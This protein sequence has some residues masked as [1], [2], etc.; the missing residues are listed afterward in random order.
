MAEIMWEGG[1]QSSFTICTELDYKL[2][3]YLILV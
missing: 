2:L 1:G 3:T